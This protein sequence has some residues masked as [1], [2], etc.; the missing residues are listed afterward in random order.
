MKRI[1]FVLIYILLVNICL[2]SQES[3]EQIQEFIIEEILNDFPKF[4]EI[5][6]PEQAIEEYGGY[7]IRVHQYLYG[8]CLHI[9][10]EYQRC[11]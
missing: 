10:Y 4:L 11:K 6:N 1:L 2:S 3:R 9:F 7:V 8:D 5:D